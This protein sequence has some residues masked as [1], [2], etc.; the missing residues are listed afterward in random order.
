MRCKAGLAVQTAKQKPLSLPAD[1]WP[2]LAR[3]NRADYLA[4][5]DEAIK[6]YES[7]KTAGRG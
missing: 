4:S 1:Q 2:D 5:L 3:K 7:H 6:T